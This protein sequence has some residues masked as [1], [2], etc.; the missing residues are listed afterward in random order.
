MTGRGN[1]IIARVSLG[2]KEAP[3]MNRLESKGGIDLQIP[4]GQNGICREK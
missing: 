3:E 4:A 1:N 2:H